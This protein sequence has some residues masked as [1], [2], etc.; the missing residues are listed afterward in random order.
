VDNYIES[1]VSEPHNK[2]TVYENNFMVDSCDDLSWMTIED[3]Q[4]DVENFDSELA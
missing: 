2:T 3:L 4:K 1:R